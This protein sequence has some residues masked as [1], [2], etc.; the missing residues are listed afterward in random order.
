MNTN[1]V[2]MKWQQFNFRS[3]GRALLTGVKSTPLLL[4]KHPVKTL[5]GAASIFLACYAGSAGKGLA[6][7][8][9]GV[10]FMKP[11]P[12]KISSS[13]AGSPSLAVLVPLSFGFF[14]AYHAVDDRVKARDAAYEAALVS[15]A[16]QTLISGVPETVQM[17]Y[18]WDH[19]FR[20]NVT[21]SGVV[22]VKAE[23]VARDGNCFT[24]KITSRGKGKE[25]KFCV[26][27]DGYDF[28][29]S[30]PVPASKP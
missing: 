5:I 2:S 23:L 25:Q 11:I 24:S 22:D 16:Q 30:I 18:T 8:G 26:R 13:Y 17:P 19:P 21:R 29:K 15:A 9:L 20:N 14:M 3:A 27:P 4:R 7:M 28:A 6:L 10:M 12:K 1:F